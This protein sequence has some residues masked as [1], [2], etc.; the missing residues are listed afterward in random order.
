M[1]HDNNV[2]KLSTKHGFEDLHDLELETSK[3][4]REKKLAKWKFAGIAIM[5]ILLAIT[6]LMSGVFFSNL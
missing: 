6:S 4:Y 5:F 2:I 3:I 1:E